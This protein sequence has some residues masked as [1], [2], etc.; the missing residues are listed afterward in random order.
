MNLPLLAW[1]TDAVNNKIDHALS[2]D[3]A[4]NLTNN[5]NKKLQI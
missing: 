3:F 2:W 4:N 1:D 5:I